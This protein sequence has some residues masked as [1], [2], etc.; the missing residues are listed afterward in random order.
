MRYNK[1]VFY[2]TISWAIML[3]PGDAFAHASTV[4]IEMTPEGFNPREVTADTETIINF[5][6]KDSVDRWPASNVHPTHDVYPAFDSQHP[7]PPGGLW[8]FRPKQAGEFKY[9]DHLL[10]HRRGTLTVTPE[11]RAD[12]ITDS[13]PPIE[14]S[15]L[16]RVRTRTTSF[17]AHVIESL[18]GLVSRQPLD[19]AEFESLSEQQQYDYLSSLQKRHGSAAAWQYVKSTYTDSAGAALRGRAHDLAHFVGELIFKNQGLGG[20]SLCDTTFAFGCYHGFTEAAFQESLGPLHDIAR[21]CEKIGSI[22]SGP[23]ASCLHGIGH[24]V[25]TYF[26]AVELQPAI[27]TC[28]SLIHGATYCHDGVFMEFSF[29][30]PPSFYNIS[31]P[32]Y[33][34]T[35]I[36]PPYQPACARNQPHVMQQQFNMSKAA[37]A[38]ACAKAGAAIADPCVDAIGFAI[39]HDSNG[40]AGA[41]AAECQKLG[42]QQLQTQ[43]TAAAAGELVFQNFPNWQAAA[44]AACQSLPPPDQATCYQR[45]QTTAQNYSRQ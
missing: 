29:S 15:F 37:I 27:D 35:T 11:K 9:H 14:P 20:L 4:V 30:A 31:E 2:F 19:P 17:L 22:S 32:L 39:A 21:A 25:A 43:C 12:S 10:P 38:E 26:D 3:W 36:D 13:T 6:N 40:Q 8:I 5:V 16:S 44:P 28:N 45:I 7:I 41:I 42:S 24:G 18:R 23:W 1:T 33:P 34:C